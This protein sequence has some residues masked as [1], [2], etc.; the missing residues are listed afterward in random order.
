[1]PAYF[2]KAHAVSGHTAAPDPSANQ[3]S[4]PN[5]ATP[6]VFCFTFASLDGIGYDRQISN[7]DT[8][9]IG[10]THFRNLP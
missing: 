8:T 2:F 6:M 1:M 7:C 5:V 9:T 3:P 10:K 4:A